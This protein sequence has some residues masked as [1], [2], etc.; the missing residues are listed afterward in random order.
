MFNYYNQ[1]FFHRSFINNFFYIFKNLFI[2]TV[3]LILKK[4]FVFKIS[5]KYTNF[6]L[7]FE[8]LKKKMGGR[9]IF[10]FREKIEPL[11]EYG[12]KLIKRD[13]ICIDAG[14]NQGIYTVPFAKI[15]GPNGRVI[16]IEPIKYA[17]ELIIKNAKLNKLNNIHIF[18]GVVSSRN[19]STILDLTEGVGS[20][21]ITRNF[22]RKNFLKV[23]SVT[24]DVLIKN[25]NIKKVNF[26][27]MDIE[28][29]ELSALKGAKETIKKNHPI[30][31]L[32]CD[33]KSFDKINKFLKK[34]SYNAFLYNSRGSLYKINSISE[35]Q[36]NI[37]FCK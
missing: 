35:D 2:L 23:R 10:V 29:S 6:K 21:S 33:I 19:C 26:I 24:I 3:F 11:M 37:F 15:V 20:A 13:N 7:N 22:G 18:N 34:F 5:T 8:P 14:A 17:Q 27:K 36:S 30:I 31:C 25:Y 9:G 12:L 1:I 32:E 16:A 4:K 28:G